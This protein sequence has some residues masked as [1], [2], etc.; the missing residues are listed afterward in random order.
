MLQDLLYTVA[1]RNYS[2]MYVYSLKI[3]YTVLNYMG[4]KL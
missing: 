1:F 3:N 2:Q 4:G